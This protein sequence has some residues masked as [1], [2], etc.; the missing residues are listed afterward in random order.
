MTRKPQLTFLAIIAALAMT[1]PTLADRVLIVVTNHGDLGDTGEKTGYYLSEVSHPH[2]ALKEAHLEVEFAS[3]KGGHAPVD[4]KSMDL[5]DPVNA[6]FWE[7]HEESLTQTIPLAKID[8]ADYRAIVFAGGHG[9]M[10]DFPGNE[11]IHRITTA[12][13]EGGG[14]VAA[15]CHGPAALVDVKRTDGNHL[16]K[17]RRVA[18]F[19]ND[20]EEAVGLTEVMPFLLETTLVSRGAR[21]VHAPNFTENVVVD[22]R[23]VTGQNPAS[24]LGVGREVARLLGQEKTTTADA[25]KILDI[26]FETME[27]STKTLGSF[28]GNVLL[29]VNTASRCGLT[30]Q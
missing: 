17:D 18:A 1:S 11:E 9:T 19:T 7:E 28:E 24:A 14:V 6:A 26:P 22:G 8:P 16:V 10:W 15:I 23:L 27:G 4:P 3:P 2:H 30:P 29:V 12:I 21:H 20:E 5:E 25:P 13:Y